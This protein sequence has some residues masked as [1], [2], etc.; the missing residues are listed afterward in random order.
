MRRILFALIGSIMLAA[1]AF[2]ET[3]SIINMEQNVTSTTVEASLKRHLREEGYTV[4]GGTNE[5]IIL[6]LSAMEAHNRSGVR[7]GVVGHLT[8]GAVQWQDVADLPVSQSCKAEHEFSKQVK[9][10]IGTPFIYLNE[11]LAIAGNEEE[12][13]EMLATYSSHVMRPAFRKMQELLIGLKNSERES[14][15]II[16]PIR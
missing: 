9:D 8:V 10:Y 15:D 2:A 5:G 4:K 7:T 11:S 12:V 16:N 13:A 3:V 14:S 1:E 6:I